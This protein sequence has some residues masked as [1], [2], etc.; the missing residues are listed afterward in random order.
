V[1]E[2]NED[3]I[4]A[5][6]D[7]HPE[8]KPRG[9]ARLPD[10][11]EATAL[12]ELW[13]SRNN[14]PNN[15]P[16]GSMRIDRN[17]GTESAPVSARGPA[18]NTQPVEAPAQEETTAAVQSSQSNQSEADEEADVADQ[19]TLV[20]PAATE[21]LIIE[22][23]HDDQPRAAPTSPDFGAEGVSYDGEEGMEISPR[24]SED[25]G[26]DRSSLTLDRAPYQTSEATRASR[27]HSN[28]NGTSGPSGNS[29]QRHDSQRSD[30]RAVSP[31]RSPTGRLSTT[32]SH[33]LYKRGGDSWIKN[34]NAEASAA[35]ASPVSVTPVRY[36]KPKNIIP[37]SDDQQPLSLKQG[38][39]INECKHQLLGMLAYLEP[40]YSSVVASCGSLCSTLEQPVIAVVHLCL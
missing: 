10:R 4:D 21:G 12:H 23:H 18:I 24:P 15:S 29:L 31:M 7:H 19:T 16:M 37:V 32:A 40:L 22:T 13:E 36:A 26:E 33:Y 8:T 34:T 2:V 1:V 35:A 9:K 5:D 3:E 27:S 38:N 30:Q 39:K 20:T 28:S 25:F 6:D 11:E 14:S 17:T